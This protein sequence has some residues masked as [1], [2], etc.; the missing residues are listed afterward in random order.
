[1][2]RSD[3]KGFTLLEILMVMVILSVLAG[4]AVPSYTYS[5]ER[6]RST[7]AMNHL[8]ATRHSMI[9]YGTHYGTYVG[10]T[11]PLFGAGGT[12]DFNPNTTFA[13]NSPIFD[14]RFSEGP[15]ATTYVIHARRTPSA[16]CGAA[17]P[18]NL[19]IN[20]MGVITRS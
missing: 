8:I 18:V 3:Q 14:Y 19:Y 15:T 10:A 9:R 5:V 4:L 20:E 2:S 16:G 13:G 17:P 11:I 12:L 7:E 1:M 6:M